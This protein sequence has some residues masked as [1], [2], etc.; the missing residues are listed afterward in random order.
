MAD[1]A[2]RPAMRTIGGEVNDILCDGRF[3]GMLTLVYRESDRLMGI[4][5]LEQQALFRHDKPEIERWA[6]QYV[7]QMAD[8]IGAEDCDWVI[9]HGNVEHPDKRGKKERRTLVYSGP[10]N[11]YAEQ[12][13]SYGDYESDDAETIQMRQGGATQSQGQFRRQGKNGRGTAPGQQPGM[14]PQGQNQ[15]QSQGQGQQQAQ[16]QAQGQAQG[17]NMA[18]GQPQASGMAQGQPNGFG[19]Q[20]G[21]QRSVRP[22][23]RKLELSLVEETDDKFEYRLRD[24]KKAW[25]AEATLRLRGSRGIGEVHWLAEPDEEDIDRVAELI[26]AEHEDSRI[27]SLIIEMYYEGEPLET[28]EL[29]LE[30]PKK[31]SQPLGQSSQSQAGGQAAASNGGSANASGRTRGRKNEECEIVLVRDQGDTLTY[32]IFDPSDPSPLGAAV[33]DLSQREVN[34][35]V[36]FFTPQDELRREDIAYQLLREIDKEREFETCTLSMIEN[37]QIVDEMVFESSPVH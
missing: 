15:G 11:S 4:L 23:G 16:Q 1:I 26:A 18:Q 29:K 14:Q 24:H 28:V 7:Y 32:N 21:A 37:Q 36:R 13:E 20:G 25:L 8:A 30:E 34:G 35:E 9:V 33:V 12:D 27:R 22:K 3:V 17:Q 31:A 6:R 5:T 2:I 10:G 19:Q